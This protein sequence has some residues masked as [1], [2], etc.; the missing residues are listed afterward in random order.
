MYPIVFEQPPDA[1]PNLEFQ[2][3]CRKLIEIVAEIR[4]MHS[5]LKQRLNGKSKSSP[6]GVESMDVDDGPRSADDMLAREYEEKV[7]ALDKEA[8]EYGRVLRDRYGNHEDEGVRRQLEDAYALLALSHE[9]KLGALRKLLS[10]RLR[11]KLAQELNSAILGRFS[12]L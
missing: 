12:F 8:I 1:Y 9:N 4:N 10:P 6:P 3:Q 5:K 11:G 2:L 7:C